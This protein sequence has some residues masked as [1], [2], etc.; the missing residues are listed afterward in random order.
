MLAEHKL[1]LILM[2]WTRT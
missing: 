1:I 2:S